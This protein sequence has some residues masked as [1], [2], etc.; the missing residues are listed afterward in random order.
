MNRNKLNFKTENL[1]VDWISFNIQGLIDPLPLAS[2]LSKHFIPRILI[3]GKPSTSYHGLKKKFKVSI[4]QYTGDKGYWVG[5]QIIFSG[6]DAAHCYKLIKNQKFDWKILT[7]YQY[8]LRLS[9][10]DLCFSR[11]NGSSHTIKLFDEFLVN[12]RSQIQNYTN[13]RHMRLQDFP[14]NFNS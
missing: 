11:P 5:T 6:K 10:I 2:G 7:A 8:P 12:S 1:V 3:D 9:R 14:D 13:T 4:H